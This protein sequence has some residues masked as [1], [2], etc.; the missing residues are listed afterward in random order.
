M[1]V[2]SSA[3]RDDQFRLFVTQR[4]GALVRAATLLSVGNAFRAED[5][6][7]TALL[8]MYLSWSRIRPETRD[9]Y[10]YRVLVNAHLDERRRRS[11]R[12]EMTRAEVPETLAEDPEPMDTEAAV[13][14]AL[15]ELSAGMRAVVI[16][17]HVLDMS[18]ADCARVLG[19]S[20]G[21]V[22]SQTARGLAQLRSALSDSAAAD[23]ER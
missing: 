17:R 7:Q 3:V 20:E 8:R 12:H 16:L 1:A 21:T 13:F 4:R 5:L 14:R 9:S 22:K 6:V 18:V 2:M 15:A 23:S 19:C 10:A 11:A